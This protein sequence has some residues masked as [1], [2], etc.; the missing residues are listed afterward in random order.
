MEKTL[1]DNTE[2]KNDVHNRGFVVLTSWRPQIF[3][4]AG[5][6]VKATDQQLGFVIKFSCARRPTDQPDH[7]LSLYTHKTPVLWGARGRQDSGHTAVV[8]SRNP[9]L[10]KDQS[11]LRSL[12]LLLHSEHV[13]A[14]QCSGRPWT[15]YYDHAQQQ[16]VDNLSIIYTGV[17]YTLHCIHEESLDYPHTVRGG[18]GL[19]RVFRGSFSSFFLSHPI[20]YLRTSSSLSPSIS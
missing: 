15:T 6:S 8:F 19:F 16:D 17:I 2:L 12:H 14:K 5:W 1:S 20:H 7:R 3:R 13:I 4:P 9:G 10:S 11:D 18:R